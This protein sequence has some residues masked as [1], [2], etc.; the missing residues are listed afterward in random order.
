MKLALKYLIIVFILFSLI[1]NSQ[2]KATL[3]LSKQIAAYNDA[4][5]YEKSIAVLTT[6][7]ADENASAFDKYYAFLLK[8]HTYK[9]LFNYPKT[10]E[11]LNDAY[12]IGMESDK[13]EEVKNTILAEKSFVYF[14][15]Q[16]YEKASGLMTEL[17]KANYKYVDLEDKSWIIMQEGYLFFLDKKY[18]KAEKKYDDAIAL[19]SKYA[20]FQ[21]P[22]IYGKKI[23]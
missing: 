21:L 15:N 3:N 9:R 22:N 20:P 17:A 7:I 16:D 19:L 5:Q 13:K 1:S 6:I 10:L 8:S 12:E 4:L 23:E 11:A 2:T 18:N 14:D